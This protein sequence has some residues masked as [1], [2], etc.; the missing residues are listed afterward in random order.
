[1]TY[2]EFQYYQDRDRYSI[3]RKEEGKIDDFMQRKHN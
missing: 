3:R 2:F 1:M